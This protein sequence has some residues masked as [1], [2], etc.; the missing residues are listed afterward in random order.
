MQSIFLPAESV[1]RCIA[2]GHL[3]VPFC[4]SLSGILSLVLILALVLVLGLIL[5]LVH[6]LILRFRFAVNR[7]FRM[8]ILSGFI[9]CP[10]EEAC[11]STGGNRCTN[12]AGGGF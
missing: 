7:F 8:P 9:L 6:D 1:C 2:K 11:Q 3:A 10:K 5:I 4:S 12:P